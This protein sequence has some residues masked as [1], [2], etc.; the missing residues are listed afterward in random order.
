[1]EHKAVWLFS[2]YNEIHNPYFWQNLSLL[3][4]HDEKLV[5]VD[6]ASDDG[7]GER[8][9]ELR[10]GF[11][12]LAHSTRGAR[13]DHALGLCDDPLLVF[14]HPRT[15]LSSEAILQ[16]RA[17]GGSASW[18]AFTHRFDRSHPLLRF[19][20]WWSNHV[21]G[22]RCGIYYLDHV[23]WARRKLVDEIG[24]FPHEPIFEDTLLCQR[25]RRLAR[26]KRLTTTTLTSALRFTK[27]GLAKQ[28]LL[29]QIA[30]LRFLLGLDT[31]S[32]NSRYEAGLELNGKSEPQGQ[33]APP[34]APETPPER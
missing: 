28:S 9:T 8:L 4:T 27:N 33:Q 29:N 34:A 15:L 20:S 10:I 26:P 19:T 16:V 12:T 5:V 1:M 23:L 2:V 24:G 3:R 13:F 11:Q 18:G 17:L 7:T 30:K 14:V 21:R 6:G 22:D 25:L 32:T 31:H